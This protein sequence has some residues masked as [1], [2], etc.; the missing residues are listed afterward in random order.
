MADIAKKLLVS[1]VY[2]IVHLLLVLKNDISVIL[3]TMQ[4]YLENFESRQMRTEQLPVR[5]Q[6]LASM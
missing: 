3:V 6:S 4:K 1:R 5:P 2:A